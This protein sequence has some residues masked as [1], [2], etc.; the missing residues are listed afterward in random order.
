MKGQ[1]LLTI[2]WNWEVGEVTLSS[3][4]AFLVS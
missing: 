2:G 1:T 3:W 4:I